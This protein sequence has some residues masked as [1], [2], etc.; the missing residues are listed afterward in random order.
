MRVH[1]GHIVGEHGQDV[2]A[3]PRPRSSA[4]IKDTIKF[5]RIGFPAYHITAQIFKSLE[6]HT[7]DY[8]QCASQCDEI[9][10]FVTALTSS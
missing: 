5:N 7:Y 1:M 9:S 4:F 2:G 8:H 10:P 3:S 6:Q